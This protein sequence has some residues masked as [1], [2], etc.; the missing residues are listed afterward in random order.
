MQR[1]ITLLAIIVLG[2]GTSSA[3]SQPQGKV[4][5]RVFVN[6]VVV[7]M[8]D[9]QP[10]ADAIAVSGNRIVYV[11]ASKEARGFIGEK[12]DVVDLGGKMVLPGFVD[13][14]EHPIASLWILSGA[15]LYGASTKE[16]YIR[17]I[18]EFAAANP[19]K[20]VVMAAGW[21]KAGWGGELPSAKELDDIVPDRPLF[22][23]DSGVHDALLN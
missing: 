23:L 17:L 2:L 19:D 4:A 11:G 12:T 9:E 5:D 1:L 3:L 14:H 16:E 6:G 20:K 13:A 8:N 15:D 7:T 18:K 21:T 22:L 10:E